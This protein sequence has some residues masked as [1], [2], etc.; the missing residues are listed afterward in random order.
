MGSK[1]VGLARTQALIEN[2]KRELSLSGTTLKDI[3]L[4]KEVIS[5][6]NASGA[7]SR[8]LTADESGAVV[9]INVS[10]DTGARSISAI[11]P[12][13]VAG[14]YYDFVIAD[15]GNGTNDFIVK[16]SADAVDIKGAAVSVKDGVE[17]AALAGSTLTFDIGDVTDKTHLDG[18]SFTLISDGTHYYMLG[19]LVSGGED[20]IGTGVEMTADT[21]VDG[22]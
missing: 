11:L 5:L 8:T 12:A 1:R 17:G 10:S 18:T 3:G 13:P 14:V 9:F 22:S 7:V 15:A 19:G 21:D 16:T 2:L 20:A 6:D 4:K